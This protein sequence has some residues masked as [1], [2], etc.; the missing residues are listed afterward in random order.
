LAEIRQSDVTLD[1][2]WTPKLYSFIMS[3]PHDEVREMLR[4]VRRPYRLRRNPLAQQLRQALDVNSE[5]DAV[6]RVVRMTFSG[7]PDDAAAL[8]ALIVT[9]YEGKTAKE[10][11]GELHVSVRQYFRYRSEAVDALAET[12]A[13]A[14]DCSAGRCV[15]AELV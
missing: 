11:A 1:A 10:A 15:D 8:K 5:M 7:T 12:I 14:L 13:A 3:W 9:D 6:T 4:L 2:R